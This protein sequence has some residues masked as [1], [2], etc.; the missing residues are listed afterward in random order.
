[1]KNHF[2]CFAL[3]DGVSDGVKRKEKTEE[4]EVRRRFKVI[5]PFVFLRPKFIKLHTAKRTHR[6]TTLFCLLLDSLFFTGRVSMKAIFWVLLREMFSLC[7]FL[8]SCNRFQVHRSPSAFIIN[9]PRNLNLSSLI[10][11]QDDLNSRYAESMTITLK[12]K[13]FMRMKESKRNEKIEICAR[14]RCRRWG[15]TRKKFDEFSVCPF[16]LD[17]HEN[18][19]LHCSLTRSS[20]VST[21]SICASTRYDMI[22][23]LA[24]DRV[25]A[26]IFL[27]IFE[28]AARSEFLITKDVFG[29]F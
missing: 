6:K 15:E 26:W 29:D 17:F 12:A 21:F 20:Y 19:K 10:C 28:S 18:I 25:C 13:G 27:L 7:T 3:V 8:T 2:W 5:A 23:G 4:E 16:V 9:F 22:R 24:V 14:C 1:M 11:W